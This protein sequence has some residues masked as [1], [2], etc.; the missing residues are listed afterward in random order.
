MLAMSKELDEFKNVFDQL[1]EADKSI[2]NAVMKIRDHDI[3]Q[4][5]YF[6]EPLMK[7]RGD[8]HTEFMR[9][10]YKKYPELAKE[11]GFDAD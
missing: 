5:E 11:A 4:L 1:L 8:I 3:K 7:M 6:V 9:P 2:W 10:I